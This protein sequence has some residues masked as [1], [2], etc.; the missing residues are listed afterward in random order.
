MTKKL[1]E[2][3]GEKLASVEKIIG[4]IDQF[5]EL[6][7]LDVGSSDGPKRAT[8]LLGLCGY[9][10]TGK[11]TAYKVLNESDSSWVR[12]AF[13]D[14]LKNELNAVFNALGEYDKDFHNDATKVRYR[15]L[16]IAWGRLRRLD[17]PGYWIKKLAAKIHQTQRDN[18]EAK[19][20][21]TDVRYLNEVDWLQ[22]LG[23]D[24]LI[25]DRP[26][27]GP[28]SDEEKE[29]IQLVKDNGKGLT[30]ISNCGTIDLLKSNLS[31]IVDTRLLPD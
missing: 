2:F 8:K 13:A 14:E 16:L 24:V 23:G 6:M 3:N 31:K 4:L 21:V 27:F 15:D 9:A 11:D 26:G 1:T 19:I 10:R 20:C 7:G 25:I 22:N 18:P 17:D 28:A 5:V 30:T 29:S 12:V